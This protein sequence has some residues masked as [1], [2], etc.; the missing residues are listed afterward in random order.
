[1]PSDVHENALGTVAYIALGSNLG[2]RERHLADAR[3]RITALPEVSD[4]RWSSVEETAP[5][6]SV[7]QGS[8]LNQ[9][10]VFRTTLEPHALLG[11][12]QAIEQV[13]GRERIVRWGPRTIDLDIVFVEGVRCNDP[14]LVIPH[15]EI[16]H[17][18]FWQ[19]EL[20]ELGAPGFSAEFPFISSSR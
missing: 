19:R 7:A 12:L 2:D 13:G 3:A 14:D 18:D 16:A 17:R 15:P 9:M 10:V 5:V 1:M 8:Y 6:G 11:A 4:I 20:V